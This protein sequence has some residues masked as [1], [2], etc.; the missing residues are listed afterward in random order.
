M[1]LGREEATRI[2][3]FC[4]AGDGW[5]SAT[6]EEDACVLK[7]VLNGPERA[8]ACRFEGTTFEDA[9]QQAVVA[10]VLKGSSVEKQIA[11]VA[12]ASPRERSEGASGEGGRGAA[13]GE[14]SAALFPAITAVISALIHETQRERGI[15][16]LYAASGGRL[17]GSELTEQWRA[18]DRR[19][20]ELIAFRQRHW[21][22]LPSAVVNQLASAE[23]LLVAVVA[24]RSR[25]E[26]LKVI[27]TDLIEAYSHMNGEILRV[28]DD[29]SFRVV[30]P[31]QRP[32]ALAWMAL[33]YAK[34]KTGI[35]RAQLASAFERD[36]FF[37]GQYQSVLGLI[38]ARNSYLHL[39]V[40]AAPPQTG[41]LMREKLGSDVMGV[42]EHM[43]R[44]ALEHRD[45]GFGVDPTTW[46]TAM[47]RQME[48]L[49]DVESAVRVSLTHT[50]PL[51]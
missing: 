28:I 40:A 16:S 41:A 24:S 20:R 44:I 34:E 19:W 45:G 4:L 27:P 13:G 18:T 1:A 38:A 46:F 9:L 39:F 11:F 35:E 43:E 10:G 6:Y 37:E 25:I 5:G 47:S 21:S 23:E 3:R 12:R 17:F 2:L 50:A 49:G 8:E 31:L 15:S 7:L 32:T 22:R 48:L 51:A 29:L 36:R 33:L 30:E 26:G 14:G 42:V